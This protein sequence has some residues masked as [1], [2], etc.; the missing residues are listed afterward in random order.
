MSKGK[1]ETKKSNLDEEIV[2]DEDDDY[3]DEETQ[4]KK[5]KSSQDL[6]YKYSVEIDY[7]KDEF[8][9]FI[10]NSL[11]V[12]KEINLNIFREFKTNQSKLLVLYASN[13]AD[14]LRRSVNGFYDMLVM[15]TRTLNSFGSL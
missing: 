12:D 10:M 14:D 7:K 9:T 8:A 1:K 2:L 4:A 13:S 11:A 15:V 5:I 3:S 6:K